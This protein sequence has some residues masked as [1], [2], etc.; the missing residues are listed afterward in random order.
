MKILL[1]TE[2]LILREWKEADETALISA[3]S[4]EHVKRRHHD[5]WG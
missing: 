5:W 1:E 4:K 2:R 3:A